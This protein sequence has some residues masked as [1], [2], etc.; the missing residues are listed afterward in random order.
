[1]RSTGL[2]RWI[3]EP[4]TS[5]SDSATRWFPPATL[6]QISDE[7]AASPASADASTRSAVAAEETSRRDLIASL[8]PGSSGRLSRSAAADVPAATVE[9]RVSDLR[10]RLVHRAGLDADSAARLPIAV[11]HVLPPEPEPE[12]I[13]VRQQRVVAGEDELGAHL[14]DG[15]VCE[16]LRPHP[17]TDAVTCLQ[18]DDVDSGRR[19]GVGRC[20]AGEAGAHHGDARHG[21]QRLSPNASRSASVSGRERPVA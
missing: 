16:L 21:H 2:E 8:A 4:R 13:D 6:G 20:Q 12:A 9:E 11:Q 10:D 15:A 5:A 18:H 3:A 19:E 1:M 7:C 17:T 14:D